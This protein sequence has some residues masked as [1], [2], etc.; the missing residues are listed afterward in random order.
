MHDISFKFIKWSY[1][2]KDVVSVAFVPS[3]Y[4]EVKEESKGW[5]KD[6]EDLHPVVTMLIPFGLVVDKSYDGWSNYRA[7][8]LEHG[9]DSEGSTKCVGL[10]HVWKWTPQDDSVGC[11][12]Q[13][14]EH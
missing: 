11:I 14:Q 5:N 4:A 8:V 6:K 1:G 9:A 13:A 7:Y 2:L 10:D 12:T 3:V